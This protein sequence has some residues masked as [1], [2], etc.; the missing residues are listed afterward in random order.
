M[1]VL[2]NYGYVTNGI[3]GYTEYESQKE[4]D[5]AADARAWAWSFIGPTGGDGR[6]AI[7]CHIETIDDGQQRARWWMYE[8]EW[9]SVDDEP[10]SSRVWAEW[11][12]VEPW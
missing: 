11:V 12:E 10:S 9:R 6:A 7:D 5:S 2:V 8:G 3:D 4:F 1:K